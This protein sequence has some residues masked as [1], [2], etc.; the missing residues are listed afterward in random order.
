MDVRLIKSEGFKTSKWSG[1]ETT[2]LAIFPP[3]KE[4]INRDFV[5]RLSS[6]TCE[7][8]ESDFT[9]LPDFDRVLMVLEGEVVLN[10]EG[11]KVVKLGKLEQDSFDG[12]IKTKS[13]GKI[14][15]LNL[16]VK[17][18][19][20]GSLE[21]LRPGSEAELLKTEVNEKHFETQLIYVLE[22]YVVIAFGEKSVMAK[23]GEIVE[24]AGEADEKLA[25]TI[26]GEG[27]AVRA[28]IFYDFE[29]AEGPVI[30][31]K[32]PVSFEDFK[33]AFFVS[34]TQNRLGFS[35]SKRRKE[36]WYD[37]ALSD[38]IFMLEKLYVPF[39]AFL[40]GMFL[41]LSGAISAGA[42]DKTALLLILVWLV[43]AVFI[44]IPLLYML[45]LPKP[46]AKHM[47]KIG[48]LTPYEQKLFDSEA[49]SNPRLEKL[50][51]KYKL[52]GRV[53]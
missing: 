9:H 25:F 21:V 40:I 2:Q 52:S 30:I 49:N 32:E 38:K 24:L 47:K 19:N 34:M 20:A 37:E 23:A 46:I 39:I 7:L 27:T 8:E 45:V 48:E 10:Y 53:K 18:G 51:K 29:E 15:D 1:G 16:M 6:A 14:T 3:E 43:L 26:M 36:L 44:V 22:G 13:F 42:S 35:L 41:V 4:Y 28:E 17:K 5:W 31:P 33:S 11:K 12:A 50:L